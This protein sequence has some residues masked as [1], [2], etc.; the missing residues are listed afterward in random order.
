MRDLLVLNEARLPEVLLALLL[1]LG[2]VV[3]DVGGVTS[4]VV[5]VVTLDHVIVLSLL[6]HLDLVNTSLAV[7]A[8][9]G[10]RYLI[11]ADSIAVAGI[12]SEMFIQ[13]LISI[14]GWL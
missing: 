7:I 14:M 5:A 9:S 6:N 10:P 13:G 12:L 8:G 4:L 2:V 1:L 3:G 11:K